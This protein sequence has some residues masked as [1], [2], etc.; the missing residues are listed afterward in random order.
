M[1]IIE[2]RYGFEDNFKLVIKILT[3]EGNLTLLDINFKDEIVDFLIQNFKLDKME[4]PWMYDPMGEFTRIVKANKKYP[5]FNHESR[6]HIEYFSNQKDND[7]ETSQK[8]EF[9]MLYKL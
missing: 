8:R 9:Y 1:I 2:S 3:I 4:L 7:V 6:P 5:T